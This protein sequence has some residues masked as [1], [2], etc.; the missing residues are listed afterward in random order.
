MSPKDFEEQCRQ[1]V[2]IINAVSMLVMI[3]VHIIGMFAIFTT[4]EKMFSPSHI[5][6]NVRR[7]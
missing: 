2:A 1:P 7:S 3:P 6:A 5:A 4:L